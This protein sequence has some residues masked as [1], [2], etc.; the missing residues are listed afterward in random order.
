[1]RRWVSAAGTAQNYPLPHLL[2][3]QF[4][5]KVLTLKKR[6]KSP[7]PQADTQKAPSAPTRG[8]LHEASRA[9]TEPSSLRLHLRSLS[10]WAGH[11]FGRSSFFF[12]SLR[13][14]GAEHLVRRACSREN[15]I[16][17]ALALTGEL[18]SEC[19]DV[20]VQS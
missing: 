3:T 9:Y 11:S 18:Q 14:A 20:S 7:Q 4:L 12:P 6:K 2:V 13:A 19:G 8:K 17:K 1:M 15:G 5:Q 10:T 16:Q